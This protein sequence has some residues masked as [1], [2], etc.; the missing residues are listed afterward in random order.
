MDFLSKAI[1]YFKDFSKEDLIEYFEEIVE[2]IYGENLKLTIDKDFNISDLLDNKSI[3]EVIELLYENN[4]HNFIAAIVNNNHL[5]YLEKLGMIR[6]YNY[7]DDHPD[8]LDE[9]VR[10]AHLEN[11]YFLTDVIEFEIETKDFIYHYEEC[12]G[13]SWISYVSLEQRL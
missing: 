7:S 5:D 10:K 9:D 4:N 13:E 11:Y 2:E 12:R 6:E 1:E 8:Y 3:T